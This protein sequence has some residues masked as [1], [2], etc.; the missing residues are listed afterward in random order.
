M[1]QTPTTRPSLLVRLKDPGDERAWEEFA[2]IYSPLIY[3]LGRRKGLQHADAADL[4]QDVL[5]AVAS[6]IGRWDANRLRRYLADRLAEPEQDALADHLDCCESCRQTLETLATGGKA[7][8]SDL[9]DLL[10]DH[11]AGPAVPGHAVHPRQIAAGADRP[12]RPPCH[13]RRVA[14]R[15]ADGCGPGRGPRTGP[16]TPRRETLEH[17][18][19]ERRRAREGHGFRT[20]PGRGRRQQQPE[21]G[22]RR[23]APVHGPGAGKAKGRMVRDP[24]PIGTRAIVVSDAAAE[25]G[26]GREVRVELEEGV[27][28]GEGSVGRRYL[29]LSPAAGRP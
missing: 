12:R 24:I 11:E 5:R 21:R 15:D 9:R 16:G 8:W 14:D 25:E 29:R 22:D 3:G 7:L 1:E 28:R 23:H 4:V 26:P 20:G 18:A 6:A 17:S 19:G 27:Y 10:G 2:A 13:P